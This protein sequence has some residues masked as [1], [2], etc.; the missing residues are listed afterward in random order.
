VIS[1]YSNLV[2]PPLLHIWE[3]EE[4]KEKDTLKLMVGF[5]WYLNQEEAIKRAGEGEM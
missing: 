1:G 3:K 5:D 4:E 2:L